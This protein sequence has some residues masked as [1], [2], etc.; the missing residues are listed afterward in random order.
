VAGEL[1]WPVEAIPDTDFVFMRAHKEYF[2]AGQLRPGVFKAQEGGMS[3][4]WDRY[5]SAEETKL[6]ATRNPD[7]NAV[8]SLEVGG[9][10]G[11]G[12]LTVE[13]TPEPANRAHSD[14]NGISGND[15]QRLEI[16]VKLL[17]IARIAIPLPPP[18]NP[19]N[20]L[21]R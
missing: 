10:R 16:R 12:A 9:I 1:V 7:D 19:E 21:A 17:R 11:I 8:L 5:A 14:V 20:A 6:Q 13:H 4:N 2:R 3:V 18:L 15:E